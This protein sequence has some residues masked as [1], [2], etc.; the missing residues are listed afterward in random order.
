[1]VLSFVGG[2]FTN[3]DMRNAK[4]ELLDHIEK[5]Q[6]KCAKVEWEKMKWDNHQLISNNKIFY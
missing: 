6:I 1:M 5:H 3:K 4:S 2:E